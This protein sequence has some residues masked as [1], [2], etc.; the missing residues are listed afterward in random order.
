MRA[1]VGLRPLV[2]ARAFKPLAVAMAMGMGMLAL[3]AVP[4]LAQEGRPPQPLL[5]DYFQ[6]TATVQGSAGPS[7]TQMVA[8]VERCAD[9]QSEKVTIGDNGSY[10]NLEVD[11]TSESLIGG[12]VYFY[13][14][15]EHGSVRADQ[16]G[17]FAGVYNTYTLNL[18]FSSAIPDGATPTP[19]PTPTSTP[20][21]QPTSTAVPQVAAQAEP[22][23]TPEPTPT[24]TPTPEPTST[25]VPEATS[26]PEPTP[27][28][29]LPV[30]GDTAITRIP[31]LAM[32]GGVVVAGLGLLVLYLAARR[33]RHVFSGPRR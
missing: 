16:S 19:A 13:I 23:S 15:N 4:A 22:T 21:P 8:C 26:T 10:S 1:K 17:R 18:T 12:H 6:G 27:T 2:A 9:F 25:A 7:G 20:R 29:I 33:A 11:P 24:P 5:A 32:V 30:T 31:P 28:A 3:L 14:V